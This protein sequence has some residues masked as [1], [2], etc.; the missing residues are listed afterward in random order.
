MDRYLCYLSHANRPKKVVRV[1]EKSKISC[2]VTSS[3][4]KFKI[5]PESYDKDLGFFQFTDA[6][7]SGL[8]GKIQI[9]V[10][11]MFMLKSRTIL[12]L[13]NTILPGMQ[14]YD[15]KHTDDTSTSIELA[16]NSDRKITIGKLLFEAFEL[17]LAAI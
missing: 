16:S 2:E 4:P 15:V 7:F 1:Q 13:I 14:S 8:H 3:K 6:G 5:Y 17:K 10:L 11:R 9:S 12:V